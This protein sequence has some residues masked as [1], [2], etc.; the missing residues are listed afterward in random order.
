ML[1][2]HLNV[3]IDRVEFVVEGTFDPRGE[4][5]GLN[6]YEAPADAASCYLGLHFRAT[7]TSTA[8]EADLQ[9]IHR[10]VLARNMVLG[11]LRGVPKTDELRVVRPST[12]PIR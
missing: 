11:A 12:T 5:D 9:A 3:P 6:G 7:L 8:S 1:A 4:F 10:R 2:A